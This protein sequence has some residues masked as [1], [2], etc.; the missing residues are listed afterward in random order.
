MFRCSQWVLVEVIRE[1]IDKEIIEVSE[2][3]VD[4]VRGIV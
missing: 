2:R 1:K 3:V 4:W